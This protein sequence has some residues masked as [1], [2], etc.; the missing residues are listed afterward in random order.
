MQVVLFFDLEYDRASNSNRTAEDD[1]HA[2][3]LLLQ[4]ADV[5]LA[6]SNRCCDLAS[7]WIL[8]ASSASKFS[9]HVVVQL[10]GNTQY[11]GTVQQVRAVVD[12]IARIAQTYNKLMVCSVKKG[13]TMIA[14]LGVYKRNQQF[15]VMFS[16]KLQQNRPLLPFN[17]LQH[18]TLQNCT[19]AMLATSLVRCGQTVLERQSVVQETQV[20]QMPVVVG[21][22]S[23]LFYP[24]LEAYLSKFIQ[25]C[26]SL[27]S[28]SV[29]RSQPFDKPYLY[30]RTSCRRCTHSG[31]EH[32]SNHIQLV[33]NVLN[34]TWREHCL[35]S[36]CRPCEWQQF[37]GGLLQSFVAVDDVLQRWHRHWQ[38]CRE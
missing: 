1:M 8:D 36:A 11:V 12:E 37:Q 26:G 33:V 15:R 14:D 27:I 7:L 25:P 13:H 19:E 22:S 29:H 17:K 4:I 3:Q 5:V 24:D 18:I 10:Q 16:S 32:R 34:C 28:S 6:S 20:H 21:R 31:T 30:Y 35:D 23:T 9:Q 2:V 38:Q